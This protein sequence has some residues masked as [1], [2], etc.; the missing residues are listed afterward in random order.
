MQ[1]YLMLNCENF[2]IEEQHS[3]KILPFG[4]MGSI[5]MPLC[6]DKLYFFERAVRFI[7]YCY[8]TFFVISVNCCINRFSFTVLCFVL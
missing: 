8:V 7:G 1:H 6:I 2:C 5:I 4:A 3:N